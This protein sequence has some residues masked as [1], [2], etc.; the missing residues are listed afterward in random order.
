MVV[1]FS[2]TQRLIG[3]LPSFI[4][5]LEPSPFPSDRSVPKACTTSL[6]A[7]PAGAVLPEVAAHLRVAVLVDATGEVLA[8]HADHTAFPVLQSS[9]INEVPLLHRHPA[10]VQQHQPTKWSM[11]KQ[12][13]QLRGQPGT[14]PQ[15]SIAR[16][17]KAMRL[18]ADDFVP[19]RHKT[20]CIEIGGVHER[21]R[22]NRADPRSRLT[23]WPLLQQSQK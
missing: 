13:N 23:F 22:S 10:P 3:Q 1:S 18:N 15:R 2:T 5:P 12:W 11:V 7:F 9:L 17:I 14:P 21:R 4:P 16:A 6:D 19:S 8:G 20:E